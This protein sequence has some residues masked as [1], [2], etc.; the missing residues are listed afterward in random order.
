M[1]ATA[2]IPKRPA[3][4]HEANE[5]LREARRRAAELDS[6]ARGVT[7]RLRAVM[8]V[9]SGTAVV[10][11]LLS[12]IQDLLMFLVPEMGFDDRIYRL[13][14]DTEASLPTWFSSTLMLIC[15]LALL[16]ITLRTIRS[17]RRKA[18][19]WLLLTFMFFALSLDEIAMLHEGLSAILSAQIDSTG[20][21]HFAWAFPALVVCL[22]GLAC[23][24]PFI[25][26]FNGADRVLLLGSAAIFLSGAVGVE[27][28][29]GAV[30]E[31][32]GFATLEYRLLVTA[33]ESLELAGLLV[34]LLF[35]LRRLRADQGR[36][37]L[38]FK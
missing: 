32:G 14:L 15:A 13:D 2:A 17:D 12:L 33:E 24:A 16:A 36:L 26:G 34:F 6:P 30:A 21:F 19:P 8:P 38:Y 9:L 31:A 7:I 37:T 1:P 29:G 4:V 35:L 27:M 25:L 28:L 5:V 23:F 20:I 3:T 10:V 18:L 22:A 11:V